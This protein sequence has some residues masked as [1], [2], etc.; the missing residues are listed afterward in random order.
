MTTEGAIMSV[1]FVVDHGQTGPL[2]GSIVDTGVW[3]L[4]QVVGLVVEEF[5]QNTVDW[6]FRTR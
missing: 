4:N 5:T 3:G 6:V 1:G 2:A